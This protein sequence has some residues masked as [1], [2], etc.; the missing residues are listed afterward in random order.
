MSGVHVYGLR[1]ARKMA[2]ET[3]AMMKGRSGDYV[4]GWRAA[5][6]QLDGLLQVHINHCLAE[7]RKQFNNQQ[8][9]GGS[10]VAGGEPPP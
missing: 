10:R 7:G 8:L 1:D 4:K 3:K 6:D 9:P 2:R 5:L